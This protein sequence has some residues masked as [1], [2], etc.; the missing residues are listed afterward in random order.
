MKKLIKV[1]AC[2]V[3]SFLISC[4]DSNNQVEDKFSV[5]FVYED[6]VTSDEKIQLESWISFVQTH[7]ENVLGKFN[8]SL[9]YHIHLVPESNTAVVFGYVYRTDTVNG[10]HFYF[11][12][13]F[14]KSEYINDWI[15]PHEISHLSIPALPY[16]NKWFFEG[17]ATYMSREIMVSM[18][19]LNEVEKDSINAFRINDVRDYFI[20]NSTIEFVADSLMKKH[21]YPPVYW[22]GANYMVELNDLLEKETDFNLCASIKEYQHCCF[23][24][25][26]SIESFM[27]KLD[28]VTSSNLFT[29]SYNNYTNSSVNKL[30]H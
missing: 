28:E 18:G 1:F 3:F 30:M 26:M 6:E 22:V 4:V 2:S 23:K 12:R 5:D 19:V 29:V 11:G 8:F 9:K 17:F 21:I 13:G 24:N 15:I 7:S 10:I 25:S 27:Q 16:K 14:D 20:S